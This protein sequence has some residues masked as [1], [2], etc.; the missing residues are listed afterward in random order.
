MARGAPPPRAPEDTP[1]P[2]GIMPEPEGIMP[3]PEG[4]PEPLPLGIPDAAA[5][6]PLSVKAW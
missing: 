2:E 5:T 4:T 3:E 1:E 6:P